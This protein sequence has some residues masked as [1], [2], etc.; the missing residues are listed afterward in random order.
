MKKRF[1]KKGIFLSVTILIF[2][3]FILI[4][5]LTG[6]FQKAN[7]E[8]KIGE[9]QIELIGKYQ[10]GESAL[11]YMDQASRYSFYDSVYSFGKKGGYF[12]PT[13]CGN[14]PYPF[15]D[16]VLWSGIF[17]RGMA[18][19]VLEY[20][21]YPT[22]K[23]LVGNMALFLND[24]LNEYTLAYTP[25]LIPTDNY[26]YDF[27]DIEGGLE[28]IGRP[29]Q[30]IRIPAYSSLYRER[31]WPTIEDDEERDCLSKGK[32]VPLYMGGE[33]LECVECPEQAE[34]GGYKKEEYCNIDPCDLDCVWNKKRCEDISSIY[35]I[36]PPFRAE[37]NYN[38]I[39][40]FEDYSSKAV[41]IEEN[42]K[43][44]I[45]EGSNEASD[46]D[47]Q[48]CSGRLNEEIE[49]IDH[50][51]ILA[52]EKEEEEELLQGVNRAYRKDYI[53]IVDIKDES[54][55]SPFSEEALNVKYGIR[56]IDVFPPPDT[57]IF[58]EDDGSAVL[59][60]NVRYLVWNN[61]ASDVKEYEIYYKKIEEGY[62]AKTGVPR[63][64]DEMKKV[65]GDV[66]GEI[67]METTGDYL[68]SYGILKN[69][70][71]LG[72]ITEIE[73][74]RIDKPEIGNTPIVKGKVYKFK[75][76]GWEIDYEQLEID[77]EQG[78]SYYFTVVAKDDVGL[79][80]EGIIKEVTI[81]A[82]ESQIITSLLWF[83]NQ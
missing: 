69:P 52:L 4:Y 28:I 56:F 45:A 18:S 40:S 34:C 83:N 70:S 9:E 64:I 7:H 12:N 11:F 13:H 22:K 15:Q 57:E 20:D 35:A 51:N 31:I 53:L 38:F 17:D 66:N 39:E 81:P 1:G 61:D 19:S 43:K 23:G 62:G 47:L 55:K 78:G 67:I 72:V 76:D 29:T 26:D 25:L 80:S 46:D 82:A 50:Y 21:C 44:C 14:A 27:N 24:R 10:S 49:G 32:W 42:I 75:V 59:F 3:T 30:K 77:E 79:S 63:G 36:S 37:V 54:F 33:M 60:N 65:S 73:P 71:G 58:T 8:K 5:A 2:T 6:A 48:A 68:E 41:E 74:A 16:I